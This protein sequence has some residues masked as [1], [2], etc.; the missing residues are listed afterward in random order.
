RPAQVVARGP[1]APLHRARPA[2]EERQPSGDGE[3]AR[4][5]PHDTL[6]QDAQVRSAGEVL[7]PRPRRPLRQYFSR[8]YQ[9]AA[10]ARRRRL[11]VEALTAPSYL[12]SNVTKGQKTY[13]IAAD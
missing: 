8:R 10:T 4:H 13:Q 2:R 3:G 9:R 6:Q 11:E 12:L 5:Q 1:G 7:T